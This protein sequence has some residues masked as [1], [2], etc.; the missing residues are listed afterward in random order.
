M[1]KVC[2]E[3]LGLVKSRKKEVTSSSRIW[4]IPKERSINYQKKNK[5]KTP[6]DCQT[7]RFGPICKYGGL[8]IL[9][10][11]AQKMCQEQE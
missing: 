5:K 6:I 11:A 2:K 7:T 8:G 9:G 10:S 1:P 4:Y 3:A